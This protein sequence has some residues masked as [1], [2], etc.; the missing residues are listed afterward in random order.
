MIKAKWLITMSLTIILSSS[1]FFYAPYL[2]QLIEANEETGNQL[3]FA[4]QQ[5]IPAALKR[6]IKQHDVGSNKWLNIAYKLADHDFEI[7]NQLATYLAEAGQVTEAEKIWKNAV[8]HIFSQDKL[9]ID[10]EIVVGDYANFLYQQA[11]FQASQTVINTL[12]HKYGNLSELTAELSLKNALALGDKN[13]IEGAIA[14]IVAF[15]PEGEVASNLIFFGI[16]EASPTLMAPSSKL[17]TSPQTQT[18]SGNSCHY[19]ITLMASYYEDLAQWQGIVAEYR[20]ADMANYLCVDAIRYIPPQALDCQALAEQPILCNE[21]AME[22]DVS[23]IGSDYLAIMLPEGKANVYYGIMHLDRG[24]DTNVFMHEAAHL[25]GF[26]DEYA[27]RESHQLCQSTGNLGFNVA[28]IDVAEIKNIDGKRV[29]PISIV[30]TLPWFSLFTDANA[31][32]AS[33]IEKNGDE[34]WPMDVAFGNSEAG[35]FLSETCQRQ[36]ELVSVKPF[37]KRNKMRN[38]NLEMP[39]AFYSLFSAS[40]EQFSRPSFHYNLARAHYLEGNINAAKRWLESSA[41]SVKN[42]EKQFKILTGGF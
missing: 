14:D 19:S 22:N 16:A 38:H 7:A 27:L 13:L 36:S 8:I 35:I 21:L 6:S 37:S 11:Q 9:H 34:Y 2:T 18:K 33:V 28:N 3:T 31:I 26:I 1:S 10:A 41:R 42:E 25:L 30:K 15:A 39:N 23:S 17:N 12:R 29:L 4:V 5:G 20:Q 32:R 40:P 24:D